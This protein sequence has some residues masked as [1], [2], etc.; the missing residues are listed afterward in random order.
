MRLGVAETDPL[1][2]LGPALEGV[3]K[4][5]IER[6]ARAAVRTPARSTAPAPLTASRGTPALHRDV[7]IEAGPRHVRV[8]TFGELRPQQSVRSADATRTQSALRRW[9]RDALEELAVAGR[10]RRP[11]EDEAWTSGRGFEERALVSLD[12]LAALGR[13][14]SNDDSIDVARVVDDTLQEL[15]IPDPGR[16]FAATFALACFHGHAAAARLHV[17]ARNLSPSIAGAIEDALALGSS[18]HIDDVVLSL[19]CED[20]SPD[21]LERAL[22]VARR[23]RRAPARLVIDMLAHPELRVAIAAAQVCAVLDLEFTRAPLLDALFGP[24]ELAVHAAES[25]AMLR[26]PAADWEARLV[27][28]T[29]EGSQTTATV[30][31]ARLR[32]LHAQARKIEPLLEL[33]A[34]LPRETSVDL[35]GWLGNTRALDALCAALD[36]ADWTIRER[37]AWSLSRITGAGRDELENIETDERGKPLHDPD[38]EPL[39]EGFDQTRRYP[40]TDPSFWAEPSARARALDAPRLRFGYPLSPDSVLD[41]LVGPRTHQGVRRTLVTE[42]ALL[43][44]GGTSGLR[45]STQPLLIDVDDWI[46]RQEHLLA[47]MREALAPQ[48]PGDRR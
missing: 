17:H 25:L 44:G 36:D 6:A 35:L 40:P 12:A 46:A 21:L 31:A 29:S 32:V 30:H 8:H 45:G 7:R 38:R 20:E 26:A 22:R 39:R 1:A 33:C 16:V 9:A 23:R 34:D 10:L 47:L 24:A 13:G 37:A 5:A 14:A 41:E 11:L 43:S 48:R 27:A 2:A 15:S 4:L 19:L 28:L 18:P 42:F 3:R